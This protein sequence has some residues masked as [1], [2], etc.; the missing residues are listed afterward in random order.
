MEPRGQPVAVSGKSTRPVSL[1][2]QAKAVATR[3]HRC[4]TTLA[5]MRSIAAHLSYRRGSLHHCLWGRSGLKV[6]QG[7]W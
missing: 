1:E 5:R 6:T 4:L 7:D 2:S 3:C